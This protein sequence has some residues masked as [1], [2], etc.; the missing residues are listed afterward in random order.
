VTDFDYIPIETTEGHRPPS[1]AAD[2]L[3]IGLAV[4]A[5]CGGLLIAA[6]NLFGA[7]DAVSVASGSPSPSAQASRTPRPS[8]TPRPRIEVDLRPAI[9]PSRSPEP[10]LFSGWIRATTDLV[11]RSA[12]RADANELGILAEGSVAQVDEW[13]EAP[14]DG[15]GWL[16]VNTP[17][18]QGWVATRDGD[19]PL[20]ERYSQNWYAWSSSIWTIAAGDEGFLAV[21][22]GGGRSDQVSGP[23]A[24]VSADGARWRTVEVPPEW[25]AGWSPSIAWG[26]AEWLSAVVVDDGSGPR[27]WFS[28][29]EDGRDWGSLGVLDS[30]PRDSW[31]GQLVASERGYLLFTSGQRS[32]FWFSV[33]GVTWRE[34]EESGLGQQASV[35]S[36]ATGIGFY[37]WEED[38]WGVPAKEPAEAAFSVDGRTWLAVEGGPAGNARQITSVGDRLVGMDVDPVTSEARV[39]VGIRARSS[40]AWLRDTDGEALFR[41]AVPSSLI[42]DGQRVVAFGW[43]RST[44][45]ALVWT[46][47]PTGWARSRLPAAFDGIPRLAA[48]G[49]TGLVVVGSRPTLRGLNPIFWHQTASGSWA[50]ERSPT[51]PVAPDPTP[52][53]CGAPPRDALDY[54]VLDRVLAIACFGGEPITFRAWAAECEGCYGSADGTY[55]EAWLLGLTG[56]QLYLSPVRDDTGGWW[57]PAVLHPSL[58]YDASWPGQWLEVTGHFDDPAASNCRYTPSAGELWYYEGRQATVNQCRQ[59]FVVTQVSVVS[60]P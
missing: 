10:S 56:D 25:V 34:T 36:V 39:W 18:P 28:Q 3:L 50:P 13:N 15:M 48:G 31:M 22:T 8:P 6:G 11:V 20:A 2:R 47:G 27:V 59:Q 9:L 38:G 53:Q 29:S 52:D 4:V 55:V 17:Q 35:R 44:E 54:V 40:V 5:L 7:D 45:E 24:M 12:A 49:P 33:D 41:D 32:S 58:E 43:D 46:L 37:A 30:L 1:P 57:N 51:L 19:T 42:S 23:M 21:G 26:P 16:H 14:D 60:G